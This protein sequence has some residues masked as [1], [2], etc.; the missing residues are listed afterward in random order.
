MCTWLGARALRVAVLLLGILAVASSFKSEDFKV[1]ILESR[2]PHFLHLWAAATL[3]LHFCYYRDAQ[4]ARSALDCG[5]IAVRVP[6][7]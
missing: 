1:C 5:K 7:I 4:T 3:T 6:I 2:V